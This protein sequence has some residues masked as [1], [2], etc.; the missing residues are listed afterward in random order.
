MLSSKIKVAVLRGGPSH[1]YEDSL[2]TGHHILS[3]LQQMPE[4]YEPLDIFI[5]KDGDWH[6]LG[7]VDEPHKILSRADVVWNALHGHYGES[8]EV[9]QLFKGV[10]VPF[11]GSGISGSAFSH[12][13]EMSKNL[14][15][16]HN[17]PTP[18][19][20]MVDEVSVT[21]EQ[22]ITIFRTY[23]HPVVVKPA[24]GVRALGVTLAHTFQELKEAVKKCFE[25]TPKVLVEEYVSGTVV[26]CAVV[27][28]AK[29]E[30]LYALMP[31]HT[32]TEHRRVRPRPEENKIIE[33]MAKKAHEALG[34]RHYSS[35]DFIITPRGKI[36]ILETNSQP[37][38]HENSPLHHSLEAV[39]WKPKDFAHHCL[40][41]ALKRGD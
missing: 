12:N 16:L 4:E 30:R 5:S 34:L 36:Y 25:H 6:H 7:L 14:Y 27:E 28:N 2:K 1:A 38:F 15:R 37:V 20:E 31:I 18:G 3:L 22:L 10:H 23:L 13:K 21:E 19:G 17:L 26:S 35:S 41:L 32:E 9:Q 40:K 29:G 24:T 11:V 33:E 39:G 8:G